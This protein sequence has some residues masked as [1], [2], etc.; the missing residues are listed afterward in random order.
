MQFDIDA[1]L[2][3][4]RREHV[5][6]ATGLP[7]STIYGRI[8]AGTFPAPVKIGVRSVGWRRCD[9]DAWLANPAGYKTEV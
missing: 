9:I 8:K 6:A 7:L 4:L 1:R 2:V 3:L 5:V